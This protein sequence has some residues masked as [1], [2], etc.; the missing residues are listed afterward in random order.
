[1]AI[2]LCVSSYS[3]L[4]W[5]QQNKKTIEQTVDWFAEAGLKHIELS[6]LGELP[7]ANPVKLATRL[8]KRCEKHGMRVA[9]YCIGAELL[10]SA[11]KQ[12]AEIKRLC[13]HVDIAAALGAPSMRHDVTRGFDS[14]KTY[15]GPRTM[16]AALKNVVPA[17]RKIADYAQTQGVKTSLE[18]HGF[19]MQAPKRVVKLLE[20]V[21]HPNFGLT[22]DMGNF[23]CVNADPIA[24]VEQCVKYAQ[25]V[26]VK[27]FHVKPKKAMPPSGWFA[28]PTPI[29][30]RG[31]IVG[32]GVIDIPRQIKI[33]KKA[34]YKGVL[35][36]EFEGMEE[37]TK[38]VKLGLEYLRG[39]L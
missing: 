32:H 39:L 7:V 37:P 19:Y 17:I 21:A 9:S 20:T 29:A 36:L 16:G 12:K 15:K 33:I 3:L 35:S 2:E 24:A 13:E 25:M 27:D 26:H 23:L 10:L 14:Y 18:N 30:L 11:P 22:L 31:A 4:K 5:R 34:G 28:T 38:A 8:R 6:G 1:M